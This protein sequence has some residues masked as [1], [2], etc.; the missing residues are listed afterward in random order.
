MPQRIDAARVVVSVNMKSPG[1]ENHR[2]G[3]TPRQNRM[4]L[5]P[6]AE[7][8]SPGIILSTAKPILP[9]PDRRMSRRQASNQGVRPL[10]LVRNRVQPSP[11]VQAAV[12]ALESAPIEPI[13]ESKW[14]DQEVQTD[15][16]KPSLAS[17]TPLAVVSPESVTNEIEESNPID[18]PVYLLSQKYFGT[19]Y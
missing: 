7:T 17:S 15:Y 14:T 2:P 10:E 9:P 16:V 19:R 8:E 11:P 6:T 3:N 18:L 1:V 13:L 12:E 5:R 4:N